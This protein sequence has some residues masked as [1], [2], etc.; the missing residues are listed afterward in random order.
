M[1]NFTIKELL[2]EEKN[3]NA[4]LKEVRTELSRRRKKKFLMEMTYQEH[5][6]LKR[7]AETHGV[8]MAS[9]V[10]D[11]VNTLENTFEPSLYSN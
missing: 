2:D 1:E 3:I 8:S 7:Y 4:D 9:V 11:Y 5:D 6:I 10:R